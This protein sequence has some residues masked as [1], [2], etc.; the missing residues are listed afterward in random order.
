MNKLL[1][2]LSAVPGKEN[3]DRFQILGPSHARQK[4]KSSGFG[5]VAHSKKN[6]SQHFK[7]LEVI[8]FTLDCA[9][10]NLLRAP[11]ISLLYF[12]PRFV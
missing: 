9:L 1:R 4:Q 5:Q 2:R 8:A 3:L 6:R 7:Q 12:L 10:Q 11:E